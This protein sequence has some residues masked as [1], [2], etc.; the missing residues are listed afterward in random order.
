LVP[1][2]AAEKAGG[3]MA[4]TEE[5]R[6]W[7][8][9]RGHDV[10]RVSTST[11]EP[12]E[13]IVPPPSNPLAVAEK[14]LADRHT[15]DSQILIR[16]H[17]NTFHHYTGSA[18]PETEDRRLIA[19]MYGW[20]RHAKYWKKK[21]D[22]IELE[23]FAPTRHKMADLVDALKALT[24]LDASETPPLWLGDA[25]W[26]AGEIV[27]MGNGLLHLPTRS[28]MAHTPMYFSPHVL[29]FDFEPSAG[30]PDRWLRFLDELWEDDEE[31][32]RC[33]AEVMGYVLAGG[34]SLQKIVMIV[35][36]KRSGKGTIGRVLTGLL[37]AHNVAAPTLAGMTTNFGL[38]PLIAKPLALVSD[39][40]LG[41]RGDGTVAVERL[42]SISGEDSITI[43][44]KY[45]DPW[46]GGLPTR[47][48][49][50]TNELPRFTDSSGALASRFIIL[51]L[52]NTFY[53]REDPALTS[54]LL[55]G[56]TG[57]FNWALDGL[58]RLMLRGY[59]EPPQSTRAAMRQLEDLS[60]PVGAFIR[61]RCEV[62]AA[63]EDDKDIMFTAW[64]DWCH[65]EGRDKAG[66]KAVFM[67]DLRAAVPGLKVTRPRSTTQG[68]KHMVQGIRLGQN[69]EDLDKQWETPLTTPDQADAERGDREPVRDPSRY[70]Q[71]QNRRS[72]RVVRGGQGSSALLSQHERWNCPDCGSDTIQV[73]PGGMRICSACGADVEEVVIP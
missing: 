57:I 46:T 2:P 56:A 16:H 9:G 34:T 24:H 27:P 28:L 49:V 72:E 61:D 15:V 32:K 64:K 63:F 47:F 30:P 38:S 62:G 21:G 65:E 39:A 71:R 43:D 69:P 66:T 23:D 3:V 48:V 54:E 41:S 7:L 1:D 50:L 60:S 26:P 36:P 33:L 67:R 11:A 58:E 51:V 4:I 44:R 59:F 31:S 25:M 17:R 35:G 53:G 20:L 40:R 13:L 8:E 68:R 55:A 19:D 14:F 12:V 73:T 18:W 45:R 52:T 6:R 22:A 70:R 42:L 10:D 37:G 5:Q 29:P